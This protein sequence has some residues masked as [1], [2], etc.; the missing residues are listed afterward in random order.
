VVRSNKI[1]AGSRN[2]FREKDAICLTSIRD[3]QRDCVIMRDKRDI[4]IWNFHN[5]ADCRKCMRS[6]I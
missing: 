2:Q 5:S 6:Y 1:I 3:C 4:E